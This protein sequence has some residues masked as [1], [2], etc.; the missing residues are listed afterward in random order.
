MESTRKRPLGQN[1]Q[2][3]SPSISLK[4]GSIALNV[5]LWIEV[6]QSELI[7]EEALN[8]SSLT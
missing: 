8:L 5:R 3:G 1:Y 6:F 7:F 4:Y 2:A